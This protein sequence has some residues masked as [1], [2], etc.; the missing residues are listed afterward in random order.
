MQKTWSALSS[1]RVIWFCYPLSPFL[2]PLRL[3]HINQLHHLARV[4]PLP[5]SREFIWSFHL[6]MPAHLHVWI[7]SARDSKSLL[8][9]GFREPASR[10]IRTQAALSNWN[11]TVCPAHRNSAVR[12]C[13]ILEKTST[14][15]LW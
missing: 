14:R 4:R 6:K 9:S 5:I 7:G 3:P 8:S 11:V 15:I 2:E 1:A 12:P 10:C 13:F